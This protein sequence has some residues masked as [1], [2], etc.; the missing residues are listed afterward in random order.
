[1][2]YS[3]ELCQWGR[4]RGGLEGPVFLS[5]LYRSPV[6]KGRCNVSGFPGL[7]KL[8]EPL[9][10]IHVTLWR[11]PVY[12][13]AFPFNSTELVDVD[14]GAFLP[15]PLMPRSF[16]HRNAYISLEG[17][18][19]ASVVHHSVS[20][21]FMSCFEAG[22]SCPASTPPRPWF[23]A[24]VFFQS[25]LL[26]LWSTPFKVESASSFS[27]SLMYSAASYLTLFLP[28]ESHGAALSPAAH[29]GCPPASSS[30]LHLWMCRTAVLKC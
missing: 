7:Q 1:M 24:Q 9:K 23:P 22:R 16:F 30:A 12:I 11:E 20:R 14:R 28:T 17:A 6:I 3:I 15:L 2:S 4:H 8:G 18:V 25:V 5:R 13:F 21:N 27:T 10:G 29:P 19:P 26:S